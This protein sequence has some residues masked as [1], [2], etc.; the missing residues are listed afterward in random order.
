MQREYGRGIAARLRERF[1]GDEATW[2]L[3][4]DQAW[5]AYV[6]EAE[7]TDWD[8][9]PW[10]ETVDA[11]DARFIV[12]LLEQ[13]GVDWRPEDPGAF[14]RSLESD[15]MATVDARFP[16]ARTA[17]DRLRAAGHRVYV[18]TQASE[19]NARGSL[20]GAGLLEHL[21]GVFTGTSQDAPKTRV[22]YWS[23]ILARLSVEGRDCVLVDDRADYLKAAVDAGFAG[24]LLDREGVYD[25]M[26]VPG[27]VRAV[28]RNLAGAPQA[29]D[30]IAGG[31]LR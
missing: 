13:A 25:G 1:G 15:I 3:A 21:D 5:K 6:R 19:S 8:N 23:R 20:R 29:V 2:V 11:L 22:A 31:G 16:D 9:R 26:A 28:L 30:V 10:A 17:V 27:W 18:A 24:F 7:G 12:G 4:H 14:S